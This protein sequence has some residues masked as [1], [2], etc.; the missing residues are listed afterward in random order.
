MFKG[1][2]LKKLCCSMETKVN[3][4]VPAPDVCFEAD[5]TPCY[6]TRSIKCVFTKDKHDNI[7]LAA[8]ENNIHGDKCKNQKKRKRAETNEPQSDISCAQLKAILAELWQLN[9]TFDCENQRLLAENYRL[10]CQM[11][12]M[13]TRLSHNDV[14][15]KYIDVLSPLQLGMSQR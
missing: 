9:A 5:T 15:S 2:L 1:M 12:L 8:I 3:L 13:K 10:R 14:T 7:A 4:Y 11:T 6:Y